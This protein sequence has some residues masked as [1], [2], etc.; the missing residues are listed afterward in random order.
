MVSRLVY[1]KGVDLLAGVIPI[2][3]HKYCNIRFLIG[4]DGPKRIVIEEVV[5]RHQLQDRVTL[6]GA[7]KHDDVRDVLVQGD[8][9]LNASL[10][11]AFCMAI[12]EA[13]ACG[14]QVVSTKVG[15]IPEVLPSQMI[16]LTE[17]SVKGLL[18]GLERA[19]A[20]RR[21][22]NVI[23]PFEA[24]Q[25]VKGYY[26]WEDIAKRTQRVYDSVVK[27]PEDK[28]GHRLYKFW[29]CGTISGALFIVIAVIEHLLSLVFAWLVPTESIDISPELT[30]KNFQSN[31]NLSENSDRPDSQRNGVRLADG[32]GD[33]LISN[34]NHL[35]TILNC[36]LFISVLL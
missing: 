6:L 18:D 26:Q 24:H 8:L 36:Y 2:I 23:S 10:T 3:C 31:D 30:I 35:W 16:W 9:F 4:G 11:E 13:A 5:E 28:L 27:D 1:R 20:D 21:A 12:V 33:G 34:H 19:L 22:G 15:G 7:I 17:P 25:R 14:L 29:Q 32:G